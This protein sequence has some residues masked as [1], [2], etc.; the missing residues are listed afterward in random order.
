MRSSVGTQTALPSSMAPPI[1]IAYAGGTVETLPAETPC[2][3]RYLSGVECTELGEYETAGDDE[4]YDST[5]GDV[6]ADLPKSS[7]PQRAWCLI[8]NE[9][10]G[11]W[12]VVDPAATRMAAERIK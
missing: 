9:N 1:T 10:D 4:G 6:A 8:R 5:L 11:G 2:R 3:V 7:D 12:S